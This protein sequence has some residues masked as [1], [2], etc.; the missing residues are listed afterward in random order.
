[1]SQ[2]NIFLDTE[3]EDKIKKLKVKWGIAKSE[4]LVKIIHMYFEEAGMEEI[5]D[6]TTHT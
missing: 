6:E 3:T 2:C 4:V 1:M 5:K